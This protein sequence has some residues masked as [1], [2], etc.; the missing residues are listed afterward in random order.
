MIND[1]E[2]F[3]VNAELGYD[4]STI[5]DEL[6][7]DKPIKTENAYE[8]ATGPVFYTLRHLK[9]RR[10]ELYEVMQLTKRCE[11]YR[12]ELARVEARLYAERRRLGII[13]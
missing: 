8:Y 2:P 13:Y 1:Y 12:R 10:K 5:D 3:D 7:A 11:K 9:Q 6:K 4:P